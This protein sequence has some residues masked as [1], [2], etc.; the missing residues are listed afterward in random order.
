MQD[1]EAVAPRG[2]AVSSV[3]TLDPV[4]RR[5]EQRD[6]LGT[7]G[8]AV[9]DPVGE[10]GEGDVAVGAGEI[11]DLEP[12]DLFDEVGLARHQGRHGDQRPQP[13]RHACREGQTRKYARSHAPARE[14]VDDGRG[15]VGGGERQGGGEQR[16]QHR[17]GTAA[18]HQ[19]H[20]R[21]NDG[22]GDENVRR[23]IPTDADPPRQVAEQQLRGRAKSDRPL[24]CEP[25]GGQKVI[26]GIAHPLAIVLRRGRCRGNAEG[27]RRLGDLD[28]RK[29]GASRQRFDGAAVAVAGGEIHVRKA[30]RRPKTGIDQADGL[31]HLG[32]VEIGD[33]SHTGDDVADRHVRRALPLLHPVDDVL[34]RDALTAQGT[35]QP[36]DRRRGARIFVAQALDELSGETLGQP[37]R[38]DRREIGDGLAG[39]LSRFQDAVGDGVRIATLAAPDGD[40]V[41]QPPEVLDQHDAQGDGKRPEFAD[42]Q[43]LDPLVGEDEAA[44]R[45]PIDVAVRVSDEGPGKTEDP[46]V[47]R[48][49]AA[50]ELGELAVEAGGQVLADLPDLRLDEMIVVEQ[51]FRRRHDGAAVL[52]FDGGRAVGGE[53]NGRV[54][55]EPRPQRRHPARPGGG[56]LGRGKGLGVLLQPLQTEEL[57]ADGSS[58][59][60]GR[61]AGRAAE[62]GR[63]TQDHHSSFR[64]TWVRGHR[65]NDEHRRL[66]RSARDGVTAERPAAGRGEGQ[67][68]RR[69]ATGRVPRDRCRPRTASRTPRTAPGD[70]RRWRP[71]DRRGTTGR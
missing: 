60:K 2:R 32:P 9:V 64:Q 40:L 52:R 63:W 21:Q 14:P 37:F 56:R 71:A 10:K 29:A 26:A 24:Q 54:V 41:G 62:E 22:D 15:G 69:R 3:E 47:A 18:G 55:V 39:R 25:P 19:G 58:V 38:G 68:R 67:Q 12:L 61:G 30:A 16:E 70:E 4:A 57:R 45:L 50:G 65:R 13:L 6:V 17:R 8:T 51:P 34:R 43:R 66:A 33:Q 49:G 48:K 59:R 46:R 1:V 42:L 28:L 7:V 23:Q 36:A 44:K 35:L 53:K 27:E 5:G 11:M 31:H 20:A